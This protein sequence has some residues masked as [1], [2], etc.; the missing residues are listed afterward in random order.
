V[1]AHQPT[2]ATA[3]GEPRDSGVAHDSAGGGQTVRLRFAVD[4][5]PQRTTLDPGSVVGGIDSHASYR[6][7][8]YDEPI[9]ANGG[10]CHVVTSAPDGNLQIVLAGETHG[11]DRVGGPG[12]SGDHARAPVNSTIP[13]CARDVIVSVIGVNQSAPEPVDVYDGW[14]ISPAADFDDRW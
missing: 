12:T 7:E 8:V 10:A 3:E 1:L 4:I 13:N 14:L 11:R 9:I 6:R 2:D 5:A